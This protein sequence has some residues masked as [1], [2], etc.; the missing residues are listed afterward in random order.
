MRVN[1]N[2]PAVTEVLSVVD[3]EGHEYFEVQ[4]LAQE[5]VYKAIRNNNAD[6]MTVP[7][8]M[9]AMPVPRRFVLEKGRNYAFLQ[10]G[11]GSST[12]LT[13]QS[14]VDPSEITLKLHGRNYYA[15]EEFDPTNLTK[16][17]KFG[18]APADTTL[19][20]SY[21]VNEAQNVNIATNS[22]KSVTFSYT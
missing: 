2:N 18:V 8:I 14:V 4:H 20:V 21:R 17:D 6:K 16:T 9:K 12:E 13:N 11:Y 22:L 7:S 1:L 15:Q 10:F 19:T 3:G 5:L